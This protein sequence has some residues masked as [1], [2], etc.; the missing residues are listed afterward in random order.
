M[1][2]LSPLPA[3]YQRAVMVDLTAQGTCYE[4]TTCLLV[5]LCSYQA[6]VQV[7]LLAGGL[8]TTEQQGRGSLQDLNFALW[9][10]RWMHQDFL[11]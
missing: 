11:P 8:W 9:H 2:A 10:R 5:W 3:F 1:A 4:L 6:F 7:V